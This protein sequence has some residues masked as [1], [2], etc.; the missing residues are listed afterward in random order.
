MIVRAA[1][2]DDAGAIWRILEP[3]IRAGETYPLPR[4]LSERD[5]LAYWFNPDHA[6]FVAEDSGRIVGTYYLRANTTGAGAHVANCG[7]MTAVDCFG[8]GVARAMCAHSLDEARRRGFRAMQFNLVISTNTRAVRLWQ[9]MGFAIVGR[10]PGAF[11]HPV[12][13]YVDALVLFQTL[14]PP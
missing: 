14:L 9:A 11:A 3:T 4:D 7:Y 8:R 1:G 2:P 10:L 13:G 5:A 6:V 12:H